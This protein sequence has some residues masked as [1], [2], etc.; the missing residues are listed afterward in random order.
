MSN[1]VQLDPAHETK[2]AFLARIAKCFEVFSPTRGIVF[3]FDEDDNMGRI[4]HLGMNRADVALISTHC[5]KLANEGEEEEGD[6]I[7]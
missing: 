2:E 6:Y 5:G 1:V 7:D 4:M 3:L